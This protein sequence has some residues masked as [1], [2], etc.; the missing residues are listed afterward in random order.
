MSGTKT[1]AVIGSTGAQGS[2]VVHGL[3]GKEGWAVKAITRNVDSD[4]AKA[5]AALPGVSLVQANMDDVKSLEAA[6][7]GCYGVYCVTN[8]WEHFS[9]TKEYEQAANVA[10]AAKAAGVKH[11]VWSTLENAKAMGAGDTIPDIENGGVKY[12]VPHFEGKGLADKVF[13]E[14]GVPTTNLYTS[15]YLDNMIFFGMGP[16][17]GEDGVATLTFPQKETD[18]LPCIAAKDIGLCAAGI[19]RDPTLIGK[20]VGIVGEHLTVPQ[21]AKCLEDAL[22]MPVKFNP[23]SADVYRS[24]GFPGADDLGNMFQWQSE[25]NAEFVSRRDPAL[26]KKLNPNLQSAADWCKEHA[27][28]IKATM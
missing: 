18:I 3:S 28:A 1:V 23:V 16:K 5:L 4:K 14:A 8:F 7:A 11:V 20:T 9:P 13:A 26:S 17:K 21:L 25:N 19:F 15:W 27:D 24:F 22:G 12:K 10:A 2:G 6:F